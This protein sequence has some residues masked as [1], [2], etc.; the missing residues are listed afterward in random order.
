MIIGQEGIRSER[1][2]I[3]L[4]VLAVQGGFARAEGGLLFF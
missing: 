4:I 3:G 2:S 1:R